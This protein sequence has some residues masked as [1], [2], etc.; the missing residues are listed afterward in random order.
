MTLQP[1][2]QTPA[3]SLPQAPPPAKASE[4]V[5]EQAL[6]PSP[7]PASEEGEFSGHTVIARLPVELDVAVPVKQFRVHHL[8][9]LETGDLIQTQ[10]ANG[11]DLPL[12]AGAVQLAWTE[13]EVIESELAVRVTRLL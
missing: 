4:L 1:Q 3:A 9:A 11:E 7:H 12:S 6:V 5:A 2:P 8:L 10:W 13:F